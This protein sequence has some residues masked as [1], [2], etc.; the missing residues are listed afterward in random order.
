M[1]PSVRTNGEHMGRPRAMKAP[2]RQVKC[3]TRTVTSVAFFFFFFFFLHA[4]TT[5]DLHTFRRTCVHVRKQCSLDISVVQSN[6][7]ITTTEGTG[8]KWSYFSGGLICQVWFKKFQYGVVHM[9]LVC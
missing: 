6:L 7:G 3:Q 4:Y 1:I 8:S 9:P 2:L 5:S